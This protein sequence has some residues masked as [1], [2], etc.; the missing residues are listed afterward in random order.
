MKKKEIKATRKWC[1]RG[2]QAVLWGVCKITEKR[3]LGLRGKWTEP[4]RVMGLLYKGCRPF[5]FSF[6]HF[7]SLSSLS[8][9]KSALN[10]LLSL[11]K[12]HGG[13]LPCRPETGD[14]EGV[15]AA[16][17][18]PVRRRHRVRT[19]FFYFCVVFWSLFSYLLLILFLVLNPR[20]SE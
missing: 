8:Y 19:L 4:G 13:V 11:M 18:R 1:E 17:G 20:E 9:A 15:P 3:K 14:G 5:F 2:V 10:S 6:S 16:V 12:K 7:L